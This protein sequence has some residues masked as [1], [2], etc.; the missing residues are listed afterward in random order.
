MKFLKYGWYVLRHKW[1]VFV[2]CFKYGLIWRGLTHDISKL[3]PSEFFPYTNFF[4]GKRAKAKRDS[5]G[6]YK[7]TDTGDSAF[8]FAWLLHQKR[9]DH[10]WQWWILPLDDGGTKIVE[11]SLEAR[12]EMVADWRG[13]GRAQ[14]TP[15][16]IKWYQKNK[17]KM[18][19]GPVTRAWVERELGIDYSTGLTLVSPETNCACGQQC[20]NCECRSA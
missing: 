2:E 16:T 18:T 13:A 12:Q 9:N 14:G 20:P 6:Y 10:H 19:L 17:H 8:D 4:Y 15:D 5:T 1:F 3:R 11:M 7:P